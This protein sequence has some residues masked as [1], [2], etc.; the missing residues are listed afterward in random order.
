MTEVISVDRSRALE[1][2]IQQSLLIAR[3]AQEF[4]AIVVSAPV[5]HNRSHFP[6]N[7]RP[8]QRKAQPSYFT[9]IQ[10]DR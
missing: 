1:V 10:I 4:K 2:T 5:A 8:G 7:L 3:D 9:R 6:R